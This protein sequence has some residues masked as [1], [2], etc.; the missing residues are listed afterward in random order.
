MGS[1]CHRR[2]SRASKA[3]IRLG[4]KDALWGGG[5]TRARGGGGPRASV[6]GGQVVG[7]RAQGRSKF[8]NL[9]R[10]FGVS[11]AYKKKKNGVF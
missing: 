1:G 7:A 4:F 9:C 11:N 6:P 3:R 8:R 2:A 10:I 5:G